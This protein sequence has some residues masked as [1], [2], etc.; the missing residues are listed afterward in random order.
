MTSINRSKTWITPEFAAEFAPEGRTTFFS[1][2]QMDH[3]EQNKDDYLDYR[4]QVESSMNSFFSMQF[5]DSDQQKMAFENF[6]KTMRER[7]GNDEELIK[8]LS[9]Y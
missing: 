1:E 9:T 6:T 8:K 3:W 5:K 4:K 7:L 2:L